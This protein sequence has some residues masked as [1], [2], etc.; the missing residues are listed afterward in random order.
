MAGRWA[1]KVKSGTPYYAV[2]QLFLASAFPVV[3]L[4]TRIAKHLLGIIPGQGINVL[5]I[6]YVSLILLTPLGLADGAQFSFG[7]RMFMKSRQKNAASIGKVYIYEAI[8]SLAGGIVG[9][10][11]CLQ[12]LNSFQTAFALAIL[13]IT[14]AMLLLVFAPFK[15]EFTRPQRYK[16]ALSTSHLT[17]KIAAV[18]LLLI[19]MLLF[20]LG[21]I[22]DLHTKS[23]S[24]Q[25]RHY[26]VLDYRNSIYGNV[27]VLK[28]LEQLN[29]MANGV[30]VSTIPTP[31]IALIEEFVHLSLLSLPNPRKVLLVGGGFGGVLKEILKHPVLGV[32]YAELDP[33]I[34]RTAQQHAPAFTAANLNDP[35]VN[36][37]YVDG[38]YLIRTGNDRYDVILIN[39]PD[40]STLEIN[41]FYT[42]EF[43]RMSK[44]RLKADG[45]LC[46]LLPGSVTYLSREM[47]DLNAT[48]IHTAKRVFPYLS[49]IPGE[50]NLI[51]ASSDESV[52]QN[53]ADILIQRMRE[54]S[55]R[56][57]LL[58][59]FHI[60]Y[61]FDQKRRKW[62]DNEIRKAGEMVLNRDF[63]PSALY[64]D[65]LF[66]NSIHS[67]AIAAIFRQLKRLRFNHI[68]VATAL[69]FG[70][71]L[72]LQ[73]YR[74]A[75]QK[76]FIVLPIIAT[77]FAGMGVDIVLLLAFQSFYGYIYHWIGLLIAAF[78]V[79]L[80]AGGTWMTRRI[81][82][83]QQE[84]GIDDYATFLKL[85]LFIV[86]Y[87]AVLIGVLYLLSRFQGHAFIFVA[88][89]YILLLLNIVC[90]FLVGA[91][92]P[93]A[94]TIYMKH[95]LNFT[96]TAGKL[97]AADLTGSWVGA[98]FVTITFIPLFGIFN[99]CLL[100]LFI[101][102]CSLLV[103]VFS[104]R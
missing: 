4:L 45:I 37:H 59:D 19:C 65:M 11:L 18:T 98:L 15:P 33:L 73:R 77:G 82:G 23:V 70:I 92:F 3:I 42:L 102:F 71:L 53:S 64:H 54:R 29:I 89:Q 100:I 57:R 35:R 10:Y 52:V 91:E 68:I 13:N 24:A 63:H 6:F 27:T 12:Y 48:I 58:S 25:W 30:P 32:N 50:Y 84:N 99:T 86:L 8:G 104:K 39:L 72:L 41:R 40:P 34:I 22:N 36:I 28:R 75:W 47:I 21:G 31:D 43:Y 46:F 85:E 90:G 51:L 38:R 94:N 101:N 44:Q 20:P 76:S 17:I 26:N 97:Y 61:K 83:V 88:A 80:T 66:W 55:L 62:Y 79:G 56:T 81:N 78:M 7:C 74:L 2:L 49:I 67:P 87:T 5:T 9:T 95:T 14:S 1:A 103:F 96:E 93:L 60:R 69:M 16:A